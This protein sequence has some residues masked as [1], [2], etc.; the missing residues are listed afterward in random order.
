MRTVVCTL[1]GQLRPLSV[2]DRS[3]EADAPAAEKADPARPGQVGAPFTGVVTPLATVGSQVAA[4]D[5]VAKIEAMKMEASITAAV[6]GTVT[7]VALAGTAQV[8]GG[9]LI[10]VIA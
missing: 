7:R 4:G 5:A 1:N 6:A 10:M 9:D 3:I 8:D 2:R